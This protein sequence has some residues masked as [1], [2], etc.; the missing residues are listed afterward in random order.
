V[1]GLDVLTEQSARYS[2][3]A[4]QE[5]AAVRDVGDA[6]EYTSPYPV[7]IG[8]N[9]SAIIPLFSFPLK[10][11]SAILVYNKQRHP[12]RPYRAIRLKSEAEH[13]LGRG[14]CTIFQDGAYVGKAILDSTE[15]NQERTL[16]YAL[17]S[18]VRIF[19]ETKNR[20]HR[21]TEVSVSK[22]VVSY[23]VVHRVRVIY[24][25]QNNRAE[26]FRLEI[27]HERTLPDSSFHVAVAPV[28]NAGSTQIPSGA[29]IA[30]PLAASATLAVTVTET[31]IEKRQISLEGTEGAQWLHENILTVHNPLEADP[32]L[33]N[34]LQ[35]QQAVDRATRDLADVEQ[36]VTDLLDEQ[37]RLKGLLKAGGHEGAANEWRTTLGENEKRIKAIKT[38]TVPALRL[39]V[40]RTEQSLQ[41]GLNTLTLS[42]SEEA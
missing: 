2:V 33:Q 14:V 13:G 12:D 35:L 42:W 34:C 17:E 41:T 23:E 38:Q 1:Y 11:A 26:D 15:P 28:G 30:T 3:S 29:R 31:Q 9:K 7:S 19:A 24:N 36:Q 18:G 4:L 10:E 21:R 40:R 8:A 6:V 32:N 20:E 25:V 22:G 37:E 5:Q 27:E 16:P 39:A